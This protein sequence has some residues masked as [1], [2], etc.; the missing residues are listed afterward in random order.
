MRTRYTANKEKEKARTKA[1]AKANR[2]KCNAHTAKYRSKKLNATPSWLTKEQLVEITAFYKKAKELE[3]VTGVKHHVDHIIPLQG[4]TVSGLHV[5][6]N[7]EILTEEQH[8]IAH[9]ELRKNYGRTASN[10]KQ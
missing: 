1:Y 4:K 6:W 8:L 3:K 7:L 9:E 2:D 5:P 10:D